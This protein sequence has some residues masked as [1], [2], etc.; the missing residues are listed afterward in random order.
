MPAPAIKMQ[1]GLDRYYANAIPIPITP[2]SA[3]DT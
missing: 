3:F 2:L 1:G